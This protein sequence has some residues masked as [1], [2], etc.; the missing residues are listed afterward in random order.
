MS[1]AP[2]ICIV[3]APVDIYHVKLFCCPLKPKYDYEQKLL[4]EFP[5]GN[6]SAPSNKILSLGKFD[7]YPFLPPKLW[8]LKNILPVEKEK[9]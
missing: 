8:G 1:H 2:L 4:A 7:S 5:T 6:L 9:L 3:L